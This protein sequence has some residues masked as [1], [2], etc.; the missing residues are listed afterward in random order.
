MGNL[1]VNYPTSSVLQVAK[2]SLRALSVEQGDSNALQE[3]NV[4]RLVNA[5][6][7]LPATEANIFRILL[8]RCRCGLQRISIEQ[9][10]INVCCQVFCNH[11]G[12]PVGLFGLMVTVNELS[13][14]SGSTRHKPLLES[15]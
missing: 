12:S 2:Q 13:S 3:V 14:T 11:A 9:K 7:L 15:P 10:A 4:V 8:Y 1:A 5:R 6:I